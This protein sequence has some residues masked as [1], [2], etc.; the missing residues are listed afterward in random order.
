[1]SLSAGFR[2]LRAWLAASVL[3]CAFPATA[4]LS[5]YTSWGTLPPVS[6]ANQRTVDFSGASTLANEGTSRLT[7]ASSASTCPKLFGICLLGTS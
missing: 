1:M 5:V 6:A 3:A 2:S 4:G 7:Y